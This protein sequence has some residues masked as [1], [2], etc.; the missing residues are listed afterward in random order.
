M[1]HQP[2]RAGEQTEV[3]GGK[4]RGV[5]TELAGEVEQGAL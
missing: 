2:R 5:T 4:A 1:E 3:L